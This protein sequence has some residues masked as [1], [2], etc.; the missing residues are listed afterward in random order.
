M[1][2]RRGTTRVCLRGL[3]LGWIVAL[4]L[5]ICALSAAQA[6]AFT[7]QGHVFGFAFAGNGEGAFGKPGGVAVDEASGDVYVVDGAHERVE[8]FTPNGKGGYAFVSAFRVDSPGAVAVDNAAGS[9]SRGDVY[10]VG[11]QEAGAEAAERDYLYK[12]TAAGEKIFRK[13]VFKTKEG[14]EPVEA[15]ELEDI[16][17]V[18]VEPDG[19]LWVY[20][21]EE[22]RLS[23]FDDSVVNG[24]V[25]SLT[26]AEFEGAESRIGQCVARPDFAV[27]PGAEAF[28]VGYE[29]E[30]SGE[31]CPGAEGGAPDPFLVAKLDGS[32]KTLLSKE[33]DRADATGVALDP[34]SA[35]VYLDEGGS[36]AALT[37]EGVLIQRFGS[38]QLKAGGGLALDSQTDE[39][40]VVDAASDQV[41]VFIPEASGPPLV[42]SVSARNLTPSSSSLEAEVDPR[43]AETE[44]YFQY[45]T[46]DCRTTPSTC[47]QIPL[48]AGELKPGFGDQGITVEVR[49]LQPATAYFYRLLVKNSFGGPIEGAPSPNTFTTLPSPSVL[50]DGRAWELVSPTDKHGAAI[51]SLPHE[52]GAMIM[53]AADG[54]AITWVANGSL[55]GEP[56]GNRSPELDQLLSTRGTDGW[57]TENLE[58]PHTSGRGIEKI[59]PLGVE[60]Q[61][62]SADLSLGLLQ[63][64][65]PVALRRTGTRAARS[66]AALA[67]SKRK[68]DLFAR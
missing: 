38:E 63:P 19:T 10:V 26:P 65:V 15:L 27:A 28:Y 2:G 64:A 57:Q 30:N 36:V 54:S 13:S 58:T 50:P 21:G 22:G 39:V 4:S 6:G 8:R 52:G 62:F 25:P 3:P 42:D 47:T 67:R 59:E 37:G 44:Y 12:F 33:L 18:A 16:Q 66:A 24:W 56:Q 32:G 20:W 23:G 49:G 41:D 11:S 35:D 55:T 43:G 9:A 45:G 61:D 40:F 31:E 68:D 17:S 7:H 29:R 46:Q 34:A 53:A 14:K 51:E 1:V 5:L 48:P 60:Y